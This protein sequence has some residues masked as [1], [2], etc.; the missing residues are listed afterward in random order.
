MNT[1][2][3]D[4][5]IVTDRDLKA[6]QFIKDSLDMYECAA[7]LSCRDMGKDIVFENLVK[8][9]SQ[10]KGEEEVLAADVTDLVDLEEALDT[11]ENAENP[12]VAV[13]NF[14][15][16]EDI[17]FALR[18]L[19]NIRTKRDAAFVY[20]VFVNLRHVRELIASKDKALFRSVYMITPFDKLDSMKLL[21]DFEFRYSRK[22]T[23]ELKQEI[24]KLAQGQVGLMKSLF[25]YAV[26]NE[27]K[28]PDTKELLEL[29]SVI[30]RLE[31]ILND[32]FETMKDEE[33][34]SKLWIYAKLGL[35]KS[36]RMFNPLLEKYFKKLQQ[37]K[38]PIEDLLSYSEKTVFEL[39]KKNIE[40]LVTRDDVAR[41]L[42]G[43]EWE[44]KYS[45]WAID[46]TVYR[47]RKA[48]QNTPYKLQTKKKQGFVLQNF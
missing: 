36:G 44:T 22:I 32:A 6:M 27:N 20:I 7:I 8:D 42:W 43:N 9:L 29:P 39:F 45:D 18:K 26:R 34:E 31:S 13:L 15:I 19:S 16:D 48:V 40:K 38:K 47:I 11:V 30:H 41:T 37:E 23:E 1:S 33:I 17:S 46:Q 10:R 4:R 24:F 25:L 14:S 21:E 12:M 2:R 28:L 3:F 5:K 35:V